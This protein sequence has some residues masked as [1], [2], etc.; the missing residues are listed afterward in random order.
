MANIGN[1]SWKSADTR[2][3]CG[4]QWNG[5]TGDRVTPLLYD[6]LAGCVNTYVSGGRVSSYIDIPTAPFAGFSN[7]SAINSRNKAW[8]KMVDKTR[9]SP[10]Q[11]GVALAEGH[12]ALGM[13]ASRFTSIGR[14]YRSLRRGKFRQFL[15][16]LSV[17]PK[18]KHRNKLT[19]TVN[20]TSS[21]WL[22]YSFGWK[23]M[24]QDVYDA[25]HI[26]QKPVPGGPCSG[27]GA[28]H[29]SYRVKYREPW[30]PG[31][32]EYWWEGTMHVKQGGHFYVTNPNLFLMQQL[33]VANPLS[34]V[35]ELLP[36]SFLADWVFGIGS[37][38]GGFSDLFGMEIR[39]PYCTFFMKVYGGF[40]A[41][42]SDVTARQ[43][44]W[45]MRM[46]RVPWHSKPVP[47]FNFLQNLGTSLSRAANAASLLGQLL[48]VNH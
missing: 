17:G 47:T 12:E 5:Y 33:G 26:L 16:A 13:I 2:R 28:E 22:E 40:T 1:I 46:T 48:T 23:P 9:S 29:Y 7:G 37:F 20:E 35:W 45:A 34:I 36:F 42:L 3:F 21:L 39:R 44:G 30:Q 11:L 31:Y 32:S 43:K 41:N 38:L 10:A 14:A 25:C 8:E 18:R 6:T 15:K 24:V 19:N 27:S 4:R